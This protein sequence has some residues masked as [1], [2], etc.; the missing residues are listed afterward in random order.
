MIVAL[1]GLATP[2]R[3]ADDSG[4]DPLA[5][6]LKALT[7]SAIPHKGRIQ[8]TGTVR[9]TSSQ[10]WRDVHVYPLTSYDPITSTADLATAAA[11]DPTAVIGNRLLE[12]GRKI[13]TLA[14][15]ARAR[16]RIRVPVADLKISH[17][18]GVYWL[19][20]HALGT[21][22]EGADEV[23]DG[24]ART[25][26]PLMPKRVK[27]V[28]HVSLVLPLGAQIR[29]TSD[30]AVADA[31]KLARSTEPGGRL[32][33]LL[34]FAEASGSAS[35]TWLVDPA[36][37][38]AIQEVA[39]GNDG[40]GLAKA[41]AGEPSDDATPSESPSTDPS[42]E[43]GGDN[44]GPGPT[45]TDADQAAAKQWLSDWT[46]SARTSTV[47]ALPYGNVDVSSINAKHSDLL[48][49]AWKL[50]D[51]V[52]SQRSISATHAIAPTNG[53][54]H[55]AATS[56]LP[57]RTTVLL[58]DHGIAHQPVRARGVHYLYASS[59][60]D[61]GGPGPGD[62]TTTLQLR[63]RVLAEGAI[64]VLD[65]SDS[66]LIVTLP[67]DWTAGSAGADSRFFAGLDVPWLTTQP[68]PSGVRSDPS[69]KA[70]Q[71]RLD[72]PASAAAGLLPKLNL[73]AA[74]SLDRLA[75]TTESLFDDAGITRSLRSAA[76]IATS[77][78]ARDEPVSARIEVD[79]IEQ[80]MRMMLAN[81]EV[82]G[83]DF[84]VLSGGSGALTVAVHNGLD[85][86]I[87]V[88]LRSRA[89][90]P[91]I[92]LTKPKAIELGAGSRATVR[93]HAHAGAVG[94]H[95][96]TIS[97][98]TKDDHAVG[99]PLVF[100]VRTS[101]IGRIFWMVLVGGMVILV[102]LVARRVRQRIRARRRTA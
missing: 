13:G 89:D 69:H 95:E 102:L 29:R 1:P 92:T 84:V 3:A 88:G 45:L 73:E 24:R 8:V 87:Q 76:L 4:A 83:T 36:V 40:I 21:N 28:A 86:A 100:S 94:V 34:A 64:D 96:V 18:P 53:Y 51:Q 23:A 99:S 37:V 78:H 91:K 19:A 68:L 7:P 50:S 20:V 42:E 77:A 5:V 10:T 9:N 85:K 79:D 12:V 52:L 57:H 16:F 11:T 47:L 58:E 80:W 67:N 82:E 32:S 66:P 46:E 33:R 2:A 101:Q 55:P 98:V 54:L 25:F 30:G 70:T 14:P 65:G 17:K 62:R 31:K 49:G 39:D 43:P 48:T 35:I 71:V 22:R 75:R 97:A 59:G 61:S 15:G 63:Q 41:G 93:L 60:A 44:G 26:I 90:D 72:W 27:S 38:D 6:T 81:I 74:E 56:L